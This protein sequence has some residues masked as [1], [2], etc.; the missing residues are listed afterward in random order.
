MCIHVQSPTNLDSTNKI[1]QIRKG[2]ILYMVTWRG[3]GESFCSYL[4][5]IFIF[6]KWS[7]FGNTL[8]SHMALHTCPWNARH[9]K[10]RRNPISAPCV[11][12]CI[13]EAAVTASWLMS[14]KIHK[15][16]ACGS[17][18]DL[19]ITFHF[20]FRVVGHDTGHTLHRLEKTPSLHTAVLQYMILAHLFSE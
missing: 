16:L 7:D 9:E 14:P 4:S 17:G 6:T 15:D 3:G 18:R 20:I 2:S 5:R 12:S 19:L 11:F 1:W 10:T 8:T 13:K